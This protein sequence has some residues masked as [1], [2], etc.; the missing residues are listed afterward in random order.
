[1]HAV[2]GVGPS[3][4][5][6]PAW[7]SQRQA[8]VFKKDGGFERRRA[9]LE[10]GGLTRKSPARKCGNHIVF[11]YRLHKVRVVANLSEKI[12]FVKNVFLGCRGSFI[13]VFLVLL[14]NW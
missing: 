10:N 9:F 1:M 12:A 13:L 14:K 4:T 3:E 8:N 5:R 11:C 6:E 7:P 2:G